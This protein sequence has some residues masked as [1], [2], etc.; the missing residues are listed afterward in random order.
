MLTCQEIAAL[1]SDYLEGQLSLWQRM[2]FQLHLGMCAS[3]RAYLHQLQATIGAAR[4]LEPADVPPDVMEAL[5]R[6][7]R[8][9]NS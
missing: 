5:I 7:F 1:L 6:R 9:W 4:R 3:C 2:R 8:D